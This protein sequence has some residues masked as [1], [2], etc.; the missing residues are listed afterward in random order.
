[1]KKKKLL[2]LESGLAGA[3]VLTLIHETLRRINPNAPRMDLLGMNALAKGLR[4]LNENVPNK[5]K[6]FLL[7]MAGDIIGNSLYYSLTGLG[8]KKNIWLKGSL[9]GLG[10]GLGAVL[11]PKPL[12]LI[13][14]PS[15]RTT[16]TKLMTIAL[17]TVG[18]IVTAAVAHLAD[19]KEK[20]EPAF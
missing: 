3:S 2:A 8:A 14:A 7:T 9:L 1:M 6:L 10:A 18:G 4:S 13:V 19:R 20:P 17:Y 5:S 11:L 16:Q 15:N 12:G